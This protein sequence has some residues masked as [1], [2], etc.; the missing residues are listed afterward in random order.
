MNEWLKFALVGGV[1]YLISFSA[2]SPESSHWHYAQWSA[3][4]LQA[5]GSLLAVAVALLYPL[6]TH[7]VKLRNMKSVVVYELEANMKLIREF[8]CRADSTLP[9]GEVIPSGMI[10]EAIVKN[11]D[12]RYWHKYG[13][14]IA[15]ADLNA[16]ENLRDVNKHIESIVNN[17]EKHEGVRHLM[18]RSAAQSALKVYKENYG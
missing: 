6:V 12:L 5:I 18:Q 11:I 4:W 8:S 7:R 16:F 17:N 13:Y 10:G 2:F 15:G 9:T 3:A 14:E 1:A